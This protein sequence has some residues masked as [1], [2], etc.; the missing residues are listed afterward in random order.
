[1]KTQIVNTNHRNNS[2]TVGSYNIV[3]VADG[4][5]I[6]TKDFTTSDGTF[7]KKGTRLDY[8]QIEKRANGTES[9]KIKQSSGSLYLSDEVVINL[10]AYR[11]KQLQ[12]LVLK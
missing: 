4:V 8:E 12:K 9:F 7:Y 2:D 10:E 11:Q 5:C 6:S 1:M 3:Y